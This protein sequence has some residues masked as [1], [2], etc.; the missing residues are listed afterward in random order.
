MYYFFL[1][2]FY[3]LAFFEF[4]FRK[5]S[6]SKFF[7][8]LSVLLLFVLQGFTT[9]TPDFASY[10][11]HFENNDVGYVRKASEPVHLF[12][13]DFSKDLG[14]NFEGFYILY[15]VLIL[16]FFL[17]FIRKSTP[18]PT[19][20]L[21]IFFVIPFFPDIVQIRNFLAVSVFFTAIYFYRKS[22]VIFYALYI[23]SVLCHF[24]MLSILPFF[25]IRKFS[26]FKNLKASNIIVLIGMALLV[27]VP[28]SISDPLITAINP[29]YNSYLEG[30]STYLGTI[31]LFIPFFVLNNV[32]LYHY[33][34]IFPKIK[35]NI[36]R[37]YK[38]NI[39]FFI[40]LI[41]YANYLILLQYFIR[42]FSRI[43]MNLSI[44]SYIYISI[45]VFYGWNTKKGEATSH[46]Q[47]LIL[48]IWS[49]ATFYICF[50]ALNDGEY[51]KIIEGIFINNSIYGSN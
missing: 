7:F 28:R 31:V 25:I 39:P 14:L 32:V 46:I 12:L 41:T 29:K 30:T 51:F 6:F 35:Q 36:D 10:L 15:S 9:K 23:L 40:E 17:F 11:F 22:R 42:D 16:L 27:L 45:M 2:T 19:F 4:V 43:T 44:L 33:K 1:L 21:S 26:F 50:L 34:N 3:F 8:M 48:S 5:T 24:S 47:M 20:V 49:L 37:Q 18:L 13:I 38:I